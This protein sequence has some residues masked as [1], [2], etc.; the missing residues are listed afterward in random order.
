[1]KLMHWII[2]FK[3]VVTDLNILIICCYFWR[4][5]ALALYNIRYIVCKF[6]YIYCLEMLWFMLMSMYTFLIL[7]LKSHQM[8]VN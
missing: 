5:R 8:R 3:M 1:M 7:V 2:Y 6:F 4:F